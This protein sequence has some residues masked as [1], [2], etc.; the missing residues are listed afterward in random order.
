MCIRDRYKNI[1][2]G[3]DEFKLLLSEVDDAAKQ[4]KLILEL[5]KEVNDKEFAANKKVLEMRKEEGSQMMQLRLKHENELR[6]I[7]GELDAS[8]QTTV[9]LQDKLEQEKNKVRQLESKVETL[10]EEK[11]LLE[12]SI[13][14]KDEL[15]HQYKLSLEQESKKTEEESNLRQDLEMKLSKTKADWMLLED[16]TEP[17][18]DFI[19]TMAEKYGKK[20]LSIKNTFG[21]IRNEKLKTGI[22]ERLNAQNIKYD[23]C[24]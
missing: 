7:A 3:L 22:L 10:Q 1:K 9:S 23:I 12:E 15:V 17:L 24:P 20:R 16:D 18:L 6:V 5:Q 8:K 2:S 21:K 4:K 11:K 19:V 14:V 13:G